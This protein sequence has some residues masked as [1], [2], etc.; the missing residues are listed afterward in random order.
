[1]CRYTVASLPP[2]SPGAGAGGPF[3]PAAIY[4][5]RTGSLPTERFPAF[6]NFSFDRARVL[7]HF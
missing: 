6:A 7:A 3:A 2:P 4:A 5:P 1:L